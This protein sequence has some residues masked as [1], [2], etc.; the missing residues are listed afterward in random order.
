MLKNQP[1]IRIIKKYASYFCEAY[2]ILMN[3]EIDQ[4]KL[5]ERILTLI[6]AVGI[7]AGL[8]VFLSFIIIFIVYLIGFIQITGSADTLFEITTPEALEALLAQN[9]TEIL[10]LNTVV[11]VVLHF[12]LSGI[13][14]MIIKSTSSPFVGLGA[15]FKALF[16]TRGM[17]VLLFITA[18]QIIVTT[19]NYLLSMSGLSMVGFAIGALLQF[20]TYFVIPIIYLE[21]KRVSKAVSES[22][23]IINSSPLFFIPIVLFTYFISLSGI[24]LF[25]IGIVFT[26]PI[27]FIVA[28]SLF[29]IL[30]ESTTVEK[31][32]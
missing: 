10:L 29:T 14:G 17:K 3:F 27:N 4:T 20:L 8:Y 15:A 5:S 2:F 26:L 32:N 6:K 31:Q 23:S 24:L 21:N 16:S 13:Y 25:G 11:S 30:R 12:L 28:Y 22:V 9:T 18:L 19:I 7:P 1:L